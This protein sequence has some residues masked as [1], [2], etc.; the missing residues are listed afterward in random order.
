MENAGDLSKTGIPVPEVESELMAT[1]QTL[2]CEA[3]S[4]AGVSAISYSV[5]HGHGQAPGE[6]DI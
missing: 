2:P 1:C 6:Y 3:R 5:P 4:E